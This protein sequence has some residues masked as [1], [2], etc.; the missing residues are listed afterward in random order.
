MSTADGPGEFID[1]RTEILTKQDSQK[2]LLFKQASSFCQVVCISYLD[3][4]GL[5]EVIG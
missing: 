2:L 1:L 4:H 5:A 3:E